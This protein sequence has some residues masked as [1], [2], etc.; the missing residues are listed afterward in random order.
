MMTKSDNTSLLPQDETRH[1]LRHLIEI[2][3]MIREEAKAV[4][5][6]NKWSFYN[7]GYS[8]ELQDDTKLKYLFFWR[9]PPEARN[10][11]FFWRNSW[12]PEPLILLEVLLKPGTP[13]SS[14]GTL[15]KPGT[16]YSSGGTPEAQNPLMSVLSAPQWLHVEEP[17]SCLLL[18]ITS[19]T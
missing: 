10:P 4:F 12:S 8:Y 13:Y 18:V 16:P 5:F 15:L 19:G 7:Y 6:K 1:C 2:L 14:G 3:T 17:V 9:Y 11:L